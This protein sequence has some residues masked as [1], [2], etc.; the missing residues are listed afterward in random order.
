MG[1]SL[2]V[3]QPTDALLMSVMDR[4]LSKGCDLF[5]K[6]G[7]ARD[8]FIEYA[9]NGE[10][11]EKIGT[12]SNLF[13]KDM[14]SLKRLS[15]SVYSNFIFPSSPSDIASMIIA[16]RAETCFSPR[17]QDL[18]DSKKKIRDI[19]L[20]AIFPVF[21][22]SKE[23]Q[24][25][26]DEQVVTAEVEIVLPPERV[27]DRSTR[28]E[29]LDFL[30]CESSPMNVKDIVTQAA[31]S[32]DNEELQFLLS[33][34]KWLANLFSA[35]ENLNFCVSLATARAERPGFPLI[36]VNKAFEHTTGYKRQDIVGKNCRFLQSEWTEKDQI[37]IMANA[38]SKAQPVKVAITN[39]RKDGT[40]YLL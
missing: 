27:K 2:S 32:V 20:A 6:D 8:V 28:E 5:L 11:K 19:L 10:W 29:R 9:K 36:Y 39:C 38:L 1:A 16:K 22:E 23:Y 21:L 30:F 33:S 3:L 25:W 34:G 35:V 14:E 18:E 13:A 17:T 4:T 26:V 15:V 12:T 40:G 7:A 31:S 37:S 24:E